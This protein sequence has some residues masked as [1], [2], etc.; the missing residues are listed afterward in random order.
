MKTDSTTPKTN[1]SNV[2]GLV[3]KFGKV[4][5]FR[6]E[7][8]K[9]KSKNGFD[10]QPSDD[11]HIDQ[12]SAID[13]KESSIAV[14][15]HREAVAMVLLV[16]KLFASVSAV[17]AAYAK[18]QVAQSPYDPET[19]QSADE[20]VV[21]ELKNLSELKQSYL[22]QQHIDDDDNQESLLEAEE[23]ENRCLVKTY[24]ILKSKLELEVAQK[25]SEAALLRD[26]LRESEKR[27]R[28]IEK[29]M[30]GRRPFDDDLIVIP[31]FSA[32]NPC[33]FLS[34]VRHTVRSVQTF[35]QSLVEHMESA[36]WDLVAV[37][38]SIEPCAAGG[39]NKTRKDWKRHVFESY[40]C[41]MMFA[42]FQNRDSSSWDRERFFEEFAAFA[43]PSSDVLRAVK[44][45]SAFGRFCREKYASTMH[46]KMEMAFFGNLDHR[47]TIN[48]GTGFP[49]TR[50]FGVF[51]EM[52]RRVWA[53]HCLAFAFEPAVKVFQAPRGARFTEVYMESVDDGGGAATVGFTVVPGFMVGKMVIQCKVYLSDLKANGR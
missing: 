20:T 22:K 15:K 52:A 23:R 26:Q 46:S 9:L 39:S 2:G 38:R 3:R 27:V 32:L 24:E 48:S 41:R 11:P 5:H 42:D 35:T 43:S 30:S 25:D 28:S 31:H 34:M 13:E 37:A 19:I 45:G 29:R 51:A 50:F 12:D 14:E 7:D 17:K 10:S 53:L 33:H 44:P 16:A 49:G 1:S 21:S 36:G 40:V 4:L 47:A 8:R 18:L 6:A